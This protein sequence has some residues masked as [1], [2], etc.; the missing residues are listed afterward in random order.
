MGT[1]LPKVRIFKGPVES[2]SLHPWDAMILRDCHPNTDRL[3]GTKEVQSRTWDM[4]LMKMCED[5]DRKAP[6]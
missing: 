3:I 6:Y 1:R 5:Y 2:C 4:L